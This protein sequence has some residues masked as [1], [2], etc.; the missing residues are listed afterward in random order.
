M[1]ELRQL[2]PALLH[3]PD[4]LPTVAGGCAERSWTIGGKTLSMV[5]PARPDALLDDAGVIAAFTS[6]GRL[7]AVLGVS[8]AGVNPDGGGNCSTNPGRV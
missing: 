1:A 3:P 8:L 2:P 7:H 4:E 5:L 6:A